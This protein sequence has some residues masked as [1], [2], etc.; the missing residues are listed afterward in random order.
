MSV[1]TEWMHTAGLKPT[2]RISAAEYAELL[3]SI[4]PCACSF[5]KEKPFV[6]P[7]PEYNDA[8][9]LA[10]WLEEEILMDMLHIDPE[11]NPCP[12]S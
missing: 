1:L 4:A 3:E 11:K 8:K 12:H 9:F 2:K 5:E 6:A 10:S 7:D